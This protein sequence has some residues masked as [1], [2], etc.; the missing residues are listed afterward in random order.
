MGKVDDILSQKDLIV[1]GIDQSYTNFGVAV[2]KNKDELLHIDS[3]ALEK[4]GDDEVGRVAARKFV[5]SAVKALTNRFKPDIIV[6]ER[7]RLKNTWGINLNDITC[8]SQLTC[9]IIDSAFPIKVVSVDTRSFK[10]KVLG[11]A[12]A[13]K[14]DAINFIKNKFNVN[15]DHDAAEA[16]CM[17]LYAWTKKYKLEVEK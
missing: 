3:Y 8:M 4:F 10:S 13:K 7:V 17:A 12:S 1:L 9:K 6:V 5:E 11:N 14:D 16:C 15:I 2:V